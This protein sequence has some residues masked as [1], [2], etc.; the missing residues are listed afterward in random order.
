M[1]IKPKG[2]DKDGEEQRDKILKQSDHFGDGDD[3]DDAEGETELFSLRASVL[4][5]GYRAHVYSA[6]AHTRSLSS[7]YLAVVVLPTAVGGGERGRALLQV[8]RLASALRRAGDGDG[9]DGVGVT[10]AGAVVS[11]APT[12]A[13]SPD[14]YGASA[15]PPLRRKDAQRL[16]EA[17]L[18][19]LVYHDED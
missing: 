3:D 4:A 14:E 19:L 11:A 5:N 8:P 2:K 10:I 7:Y 18:H 6:H 12:V 1:Y 15:L 13:R 17:A 9:V 16:K